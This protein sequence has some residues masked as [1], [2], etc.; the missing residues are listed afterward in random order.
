MLVLDHNTFPSLPYW[1][2]DGELKE[3]VSVSTLI[4]KYKA[5]FQAAID[6]VYK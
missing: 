3:G 1:D 2:F 4:E 6:E 5:P